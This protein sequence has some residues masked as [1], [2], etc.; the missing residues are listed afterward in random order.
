MS[1]T[2]LDVF[3]TTLQKTHLWLNEIM[4]ELGWEDNRNDERIDREEVVRAVFCVLS[5]RITEGEI[6]D[7]KHLLPTAL[8]ELWP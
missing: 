7:V 2:G 1:M 4:T 3:D 6:S 8:R 5:R